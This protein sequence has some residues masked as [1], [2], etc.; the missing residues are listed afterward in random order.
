MNLLDFFKKV[1][2][3]IAISGIAL[4]TA[5]FFLEEGPQKEWCLFIGT[6]IMIGWAIIR[7][8]QDD[9]DP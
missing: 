4:L 6:L 9:P 8:L 3:Y 1:E 7:V 5:V 2:D